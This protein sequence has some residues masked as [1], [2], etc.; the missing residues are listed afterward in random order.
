MRRNM[1]H[2][3]S[4]NPM[5]FIKA[6]SHNALLRILVELCKDK[7]LA[8]RIMAMARGILSEV[9]ADEI[10]VEVFRSLN[11]IQV[12]DL[13]DSSGKTR[14]G[15]RDATDVGYE[16]VGDALYQFSSRMNQYRNLGMKAEEKECCKGILSGLLKYGEQGSNEFRDWVPD[17]P[18]TYAE[19]ILDEWKK[20]NTA[21]D[22]EEVQMVY[23]SCFSEE[24]Y[25][26][27][28]SG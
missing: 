2:E 10:A 18:Y 9:N 24:G 20:D 7:D 15:Y 12:E 14:S 19:D 17:D 13:W 28:E 1:K 6:L 27:E 3:D 26:E 8:E 23:D 21:E 4:L 16:M 25:G 22:I 5:T 11:A